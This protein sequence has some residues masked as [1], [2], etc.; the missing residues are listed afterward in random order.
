MTIPFCTYRNEGGAALIA[1]LMILALSA[2]IG[3][4]AV[5]LTST[6]VKI[7]GNY[8]DNVKAFYIAEAGLA[9]A[10][11][12]LKHDINTDDDIANTTLEAISGTITISPGSADFYTVFNNVSFGKGSYTIKL[13]NYDDGSGGLDKTKVLVRSIGTAPDSASVTL[14]TRLSAENVS[15]WNNAAFADGGGGFAPITGNV[16]TG[17][18]IHLLGTGLASTATVFNNQTGNCLNE[19]TGMNS[20]LANKIAGGTSSDLNSKF[21]VKNGRSDLHLGSATIGSS[22]NDFKGIYVTTGA[23]GGGGVNAD[24]IGGDNS[25][26]GQNLYAD[27]GAA[28][29]KAYDLGG[30]IQMPP[31]DTNYWTWINANSLDLT[32]TTVAAKTAGGVDSDPVLGL[33]GGDLELAAEYTDPPDTYYLTLEFYDAGAT[34]FDDATNAIR[35]T[36]SQDPNVPSVL[37]IKGVVKVKSLTIKNDIDYVTYSVGGIE[38]GTFYVTGSTGI[39]TLVDGNILPAASASFP[40]ADVLGVVSTLDITLGSGA[41]QLLLAGIFYSTAKITS[42]KQTDLAGIIMCKTFDITS[43][44]PSIWQVPTLAANLPP[45]VPDPDPVWV[46]TEKTWRDLSL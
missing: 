7:G 25:G 35:F 6:D 14:E 36:S 17:G 45:G 33:K 4:T 11:A 26:A 38:G 34:G 31:V 22:T 30:A 37:E 19:N 3:A 28:S 21:R 10:E 43:Q 20:T 46:F 13:K 32:G 44:V 24:I 41:S 40:T 39:G 23:D 15:P 27:K 5:L 18:S 12:E 16:I 29:P 8:K 2:I 1:A 9:R 42:S